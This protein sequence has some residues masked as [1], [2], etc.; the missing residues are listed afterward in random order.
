MCGSRG[1]HL[2]VKRK[3]SAFPVRERSQPLVREPAS[4]KADLAP[5]TAA[6]GER[7]SGCMV[8]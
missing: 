8:G 2:G 6:Y 5:S 4:Q 3:N 7:D 1:Q